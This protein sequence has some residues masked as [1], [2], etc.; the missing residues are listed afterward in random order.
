MKGKMRVRSGR[1][2]GRGNRRDE[3]CF[4][5]SV[6]VLLELDLILKS[7]HSEAA[8]AIAIANGCES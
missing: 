6:S 5:R 8:I 1:R 4:L 2:D 7:Y 3:M